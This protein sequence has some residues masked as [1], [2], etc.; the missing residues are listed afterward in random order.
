MNDKK[1]LICGMDIKEH[2]AGGG[3]GG[4]HVY[5]F[6]KDSTDHEVLKIKKPPKY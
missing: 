2:M 1:L 3:G 4:L 5:Y 6:A